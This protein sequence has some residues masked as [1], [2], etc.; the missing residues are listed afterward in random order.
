ML[1]PLEAYRRIGGHEAMAS[2][3]NEDLQ[4]ARRIKSSN[5]R[6]V[7]VRNKDLYSVRMYRT[8]GQIFK[9]WTRIFLGAFSKP[10]RLLVSV[11]VLLLV[12]LSPWILAVA[13]T[14][15]VVAGA[16]GW[17]V[18]AGIAWAAAAMQISVIARF[19]RMLEANPLLSVTYPLGCLV[20]LGILLMA[21]IKMLPGAKVQWRGG[22]Y[23]ASAA[24]KE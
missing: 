23:A 16:G 19:Y 20:V 8:F 14:W 12:S 4:F 11:L 3:P 18:L 1:M 21:G 13:G 2:S 7:V 5:M 9:G 15:A 6:L 10:I 22:Y 17:G 24:R